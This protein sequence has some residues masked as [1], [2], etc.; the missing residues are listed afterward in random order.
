MTTAP[1]RKIVINTSY[2]DFCLSHAAF[3]RLRELGQREALKEEDFGAYWS[4]G[5]RPDEPSLNRCGREVPRDDQHLV[6][7]VEELGIRANGHA[8]ALKVVGVPQDIRW[9]IE[10]TDGVEHVSEAHRIW[11]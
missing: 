8:A 11:G 7:V 4:A 1:T 3:L 9:Q 2:G 5:S 10:K 6:R